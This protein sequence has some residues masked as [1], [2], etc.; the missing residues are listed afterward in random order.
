[1]SKYTPPLH[2]ILAIWAICG[3]GIYGVRAWYFP[4]PNTWLLV[5][6]VGVVGV[7][8]GVRIW[9]RVR[10]LY[11]TK[12]SRIAAPLIVLLV[13]SCMC[14]AFGL[15]APALAMRLMG[16]DTQM[17]ATVFR[18]EHGS[19]RCRK[20]IYLVENWPTRLCVSAGEYESVQPGSRVLLNARTNALGTFVFSI[21]AS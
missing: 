11:R 18:K 7:A 5:V 12:R 8:L 13:P 16:P 17:A 6:P 10:H 21:E 2:I 14:V 3:L 9:Q 1:M 4:D 19:R 20:Q 15:G